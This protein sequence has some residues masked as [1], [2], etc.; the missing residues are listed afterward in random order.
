[1]TLHLVNFP[2]SV[3]AVFKEGISLARGDKTLIPPDGGSKI[4]FVLPHPVFTPRMRA[5]QSVSRLKRLDEPDYWQVVLRCSDSVKDREEDEKKK[6]FFGSARVREK[7]T[8]K[9]KWFFTGFNLGDIYTMIEEANYALA[10][11]S[12]IMQEVTDYRLNLLVVT[13]PRLTAIWARCLTLG[14]DYVFALSDSDEIW[15]TGTNMI[16]LKEFVEIAK[17][18]KDRRDSDF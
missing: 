2:D 9:D 18:V 6:E 10:S 1:M 15:Q 17:K 4:T 14:D 16:T 12:E 5:M 7:H 11:K 8:E 13:Q 3:K